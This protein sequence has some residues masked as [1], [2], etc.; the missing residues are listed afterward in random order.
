MQQQIMHVHAA[1]LSSQQHGH[2][3]EEDLNDAE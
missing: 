3:E 1:V 2:G